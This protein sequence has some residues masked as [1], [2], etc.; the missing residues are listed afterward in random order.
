MCHLSR[1]ETKI[2]TAQ[3]VCPAYNKGLEFQAFL[4]HSRSLCSHGDALTHVITN[5]EA[6]VS[7]HEHWVTRASSYLCSGRPGEDCR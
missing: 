6:V 3:I 5:G 4:T 7:A 2:Q 1:N